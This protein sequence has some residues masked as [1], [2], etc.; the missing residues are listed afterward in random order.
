LAEKAE[1]H[2]RTFGRALRAARRARGLTLPQLRSRLGNNLSIQALRSYEQG[3]RAC[4]LTRL[5]ELCDALEV[6]PALLLVRSPARETNVRRQ[7]P[8]V[9]MVD[10]RTIVAKPEAD[11][12]PL[13]RWAAA[14]L[15]ESGGRTTSFQLEQ[16]ALDALAELCGLDT[17]ALTT[18]ILAFSRKMD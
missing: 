14:R 2:L 9:V 17:M 16:Q 1:H 4:S 12:A 11:L 6:S 13:Q 18:K 15:I 10:L 5:Y 7:A 8:S 3:N